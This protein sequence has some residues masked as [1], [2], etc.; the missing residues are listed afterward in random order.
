[1]EVDKM[2]LEG[3]GKVSFVNGI[4]RIHALAVAADGNMKESGNIEIPGN[5][6]ADVIN[7]LSAGATGISEKLNEN[8]SSS[9]SDKSSKKEKPSKNKKK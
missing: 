7:G 5:M 8:A 2:L 6:V 4:L 3:L 9:K 1:M